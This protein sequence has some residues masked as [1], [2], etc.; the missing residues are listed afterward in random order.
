MSDEI[1]S[2]ES[3]NK[4]SINVYSF[5]DALNDESMFKEF[6]HSVGVSNIEK[7]I[8]EALAVEIDKATLDEG[9][10]IFMDLDEKKNELSIKIK[11]SKKGSKA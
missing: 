8:E 2:F 6:D 4:V 11:K 1:D 3:L 9:D 7:Y 5:G 10:S